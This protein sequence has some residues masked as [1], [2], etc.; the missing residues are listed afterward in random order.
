MTLMLTLRT[1]DEVCISYILRR[2]RGSCM[3]PTA[4]RHSHFAH[5]QSIE[6]G[7]RCTLHYT[8]LNCLGY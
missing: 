3:T 2:Q 4:E 1:E 7:G 5:R 6:T 8:E